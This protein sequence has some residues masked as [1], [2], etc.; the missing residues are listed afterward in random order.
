[1]TCLNG[2]GLPTAGHLTALNITFSLTARCH[3]AP[4]FPHHIDKHLGQ[5]SRRFAQG[6]ASSMDESDFA[7]KGLI[8]EI[9]CSHAGWPTNV[10]DSLWH[11]GNSGA[12]RH[13]PRDRL[14]LAELA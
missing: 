6:A 14:E 8:A 13:E 10:I 4:A 9:Y 1:M 12:T 3:P 5:H 2:H 7:V 11:Q